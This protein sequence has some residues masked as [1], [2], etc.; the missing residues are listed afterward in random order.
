MSPWSRPTSVLSGILIQLAVWPQQT[1]IEN[2]GGA[3]PLWEGELGP[4]L[5]QCDRDQ[6]L[7]LRAKFRLDPSIRLAT[8][9]QRYR[10]IDRQADNGPTA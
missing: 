7:Y 4:H 2:W 10:Q 6:G 8:I 9:H 1:W 5:T 3:V